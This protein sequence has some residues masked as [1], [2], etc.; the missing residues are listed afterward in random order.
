MPKV[1]T[2]SLGDEVTFSKDDSG[3]RTPPRFLTP[4]C[5]LTARRPFCPIVVSAGNQA[6]ERTAG[7][8]PHLLS[9][10][11]S[12]CRF[13]APR[14]ARYIVWP[15]IISVFG[16][17]SFDFSVNDIRCWL[18]VRL[19]RSTPDLPETSETGKAPLTPGEN[20]ARAV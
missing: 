5:T 7:R 10:E 12:P 1:S 2:D 9:C 13:I 15:K 18:R 19:F 4:L 6:P 16:D 14:L 8:S 11:I 3:S 20:A 17:P